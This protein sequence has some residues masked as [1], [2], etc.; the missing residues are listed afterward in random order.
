MIIAN[1]EVDD[2]IVVLDRKT[3]S[4]GVWVYTIFDKRDTIR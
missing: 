1:Y 3:Y 4:Q 2:E